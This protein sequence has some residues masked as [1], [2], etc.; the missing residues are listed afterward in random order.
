MNQELTLAILAA[1]PLLIGGII[2]A[3]N[4]E[5]INNGTEKAEAWIR[6]MYNKVSAKKGWFASLI[7]FPILW[8]LVKFSDWTD[9]FTHRGLKNGTRVT[10]TLYF[11]AAWCF[12][13]YLAFIVVVVVLI[14]IAVIYLLFKI[15]T[16][17]SSSSDSGSGRDRIIAPTSSGQRV[18]PETGVV[19][20]KGFFGWSSTN[21]RVDPETGKMQEKGIIGWD[22][23]KT[24]IDQNTGN[25]Q[26]KGIFGYNNTDTR[27]DPKTG[28]IQ[29]KGVFGWNDTDERINPETGR[30][31]KKGVFGWNDD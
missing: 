20:E 11:I 23:T 31:Q 6:R 1:F 17:A 21:K 29:N 12:L 25:I 22:D 9:S 30:H 2:A 5:A 27:V 15:L 13:L 7:L 28:V 4:F 24:K 14:A 8:V 19:E 18:N 3:V 16:G 26:E 10:T